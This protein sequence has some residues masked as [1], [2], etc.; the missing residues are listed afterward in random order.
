MKKKMTL[1]LSIICII[2]SCIACI[3]IS[4]VEQKTKI[5]NLAY[6]F[7]KSADHM[8]YIKEK[9]K[10]EAYFVLSKDYYGKTLLMRYY[11]LDEARKFNIYEQNGACNAY[12]PNSLMDKFL[13]KDFYNNLSPKM[14]DIILDM[15]IDITTRE[16]IDVGHILET[17]K[18]KRKIFL[19]STY[20]VNAPES[21][22]EA[23]EGIRL[24]YFLDS[25]DGRIRLA[26]K[27]NNTTEPYPYW[28]RTAHTWDDYD[29]TSI[30]YMESDGIFKSVIANTS[31]D[32]D[33]YVRPIFCVEGNTPV[34]KKDIGDK[35][36]GKVYV[37]E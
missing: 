26:Y 21:S 30:T 12:Y 29:V 18:L 11:L 16:S 35:K 37:I 32:T 7:K 17:E 13:S 6:D 24:K 20:E 14:R 36:L 2:Y 1:I 27:K 33:F 31:V 28:L 4:G 15:D 3:Q 25:H 19:L 10:Y 22:L 5:K 23:H 8:V 34:F 9:G